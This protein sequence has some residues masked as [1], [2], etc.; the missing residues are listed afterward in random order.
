MHAANSRDCLLAA[1]HLL[2]RLFQFHDT[3]NYG[4]EIQCF[5]EDC[6]WHRKGEELQGHADIVR[7]LQARSASL[8]TMH[9]VTNVMVDPDGDDAATVAFF[10]TTYSHDD[11]T[12][13]T[14][15]I[16]PRRLP[17]VGIG[18]ATIR[19]RDGIWRIRTLSTEEWMFSAA[20][21][22]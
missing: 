9:L 19:C 10:L 3:R 2:A 1:Q 21:G 12:P 4:A 22:G 5:T 14:G 20:R 17:S 8:V 13:P 18:R 16:V 11:G 15:P 6:V 7:V